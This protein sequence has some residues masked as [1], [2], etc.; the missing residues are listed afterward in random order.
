MSKLSVDE[1]LELAVADPFWTPDD[2]HLVEHP[3]LSYLH[4]ARSQDFYNVVTRC[5]LTD[6]RVDEMIAEVG[7]AHAQTRSSWRLTNL[8][9]SP[10]LLRALKG[11]GYALENGHRAYAIDAARLNAPAL[12]GG[13]RVERVI[14]I[15]GLRAAKR[16]AVAAFGPHG[17][18]T[19]EDLKEMLR[20]CLAPENRIARF[21]VYAGDAPVA[22]AGL[23]LFPSLSFGLLWGGGVHPDWRGRGAYR[24]LLSARAAWSQQHGLES[25]GL[26]ARLS[27]SAPIVARL[28]FTAYGFMEDWVRPAARS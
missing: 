17:E 28:G 25:V 12:E 5:R 23:T 11:A 13:L 9:A 20:M 15:E 10:A 26:Y 24:A 21:V 18:D 16:A 1:R 7:A 2:V 14:T 6:A 3:D 19:E 8:S 27:T 4:S 22:S